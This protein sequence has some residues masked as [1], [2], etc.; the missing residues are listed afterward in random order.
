MRSRKRAR[1]VTIQLLSGLFFLFFFLSAT[2]GFA[3]GLG[4][5]ARQERE[6]R[7][8]QSRRPR[9]YTNE[10][11]AR[12]RILDPEDR[13]APESAPQSA[14]VAPSAPPAPRSL[15]MEW[16][17]D[18]PLGD[19]ARF[20]R[21]QREKE[22]AGT[23][24]FAANGPS[25]VSVDIEPWLFPI[26]LASPLPTTLDSFF[27][28]RGVSEPAWDTP[29]VSGETVRVE[30][31]DTLWK[32]AARHLGSGSQWPKIMAANPALQNPNQI[33]PGQQLLL[34]LSAEKVS[35]AGKQIQVRAGDSLWKL[36]ATQFGTGHAWACLAAANPGIENANRIY[37]GQV[38]VIPST[39]S[40]GA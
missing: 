4:D 22:A 35:P 10:D 6:R 33:Q 23:P 7:A 29:Q 36:A 38:L 12:P 24:E 31:G 8:S 3:Q 32:I 19:V 14:N 17:D 30:R 39:C 20:Y 25:T 13:Q 18:I 37:P 27:P 34:P 26:P 21:N 11:L 5:V 1:T 2:S 9:V 40:T 15:V 16:P 28:P